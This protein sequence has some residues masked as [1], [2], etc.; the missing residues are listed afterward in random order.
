MPTLENL[1]RGPMVYQEISANGSVYTDNQV[2]TSRYWREDKSGAKAK[3]D[4]TGWRNPTGYSLR[5]YSHHKVN[6]V[7]EYM[8]G[9]TRIKRTGTFGDSPSVT[10]PN[11]TFPVGLRQRAE[12]GALLKLKDQKIDLG[13]AWGERAA[14]AEMLADVASRVAKAYRAARK[15]NF[16]K[17][18]SELNCNW[19]KSTS[20]WLELQYGWKPLLSDVYNATDALSSRTDPKDWRVT[21]KGVARDSSES[22]FQDPPSGQGFAHR[23]FVHESVFQGCFVRLDYFPDNPFLIA[24]TSLGL[25]N[26]LA[27]AWELTRLSF[28]VDWALPIGDWLSSLDASLGYTF[29]SGSRSELTRSTRSWDGNPYLGQYPYGKTI[30]ADTKG[31]GKYVA[32]D[33]VVYPSSPLPRPPVPKNPVGLK[34]MADGLSLLA[35]AFGGR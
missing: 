26:P 30:R 11:P 3:R 9:T 19:R 6:G 17:A 20:N 29:V 28:V 8:H 12:V 22:Y 5:H 15:G 24:L 33:R 18:A 32:L 7:L 13:V 4:A 31:F 23:G 34:H 27:I 25:T 14:T 35:Q 10:P 1:I 21:V 2:Q 16:R